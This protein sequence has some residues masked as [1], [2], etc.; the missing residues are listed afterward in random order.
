MDIQAATRIKAGMTMAHILSTKSNKDAMTSLIASQI[1]HHSWG[2]RV[3]CAW[4][5]KAMAT[6]GPDGAKFASEQEEADTKMIYHLSLLDKDVEATVVSP[7]TDVLVLLLRHFPKIPPNTCLQLGKTTFNVQLLHDKL[8]SHADVITSFHALTGCDTTCA[9]FRKG[10]L[11]AWPVFQAADQAT[12]DALGT[13]RSPGPLTQES[14]DVL[15]RFVSGIYGYTCSLPQARWT[16]LQKK[17]VGAA[18]A[19]PTVAATTQHIMRAQ[20]QAVVW[21]G[22]VKKELVTLDP[23][24]YGYGADLAPIPSTLPPA[25][26]GIMDGMQCGCK[27]NCSTNRCR[28][29]RLQT[30][31]SELCNCSP[32]MCIN[33]EEDGHEDVDGVDD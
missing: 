7:D 5:D 21:E 20:L 10:K 15:C 9:L 33:D 32:E 23:T 18:L 6:S 25:P 1:Q 26:Q 8:G 12:L 3:V 16:A 19:P 17:K 13:L 22:A 14:L 27:T 11:Q 30:P 24:K 29:Q 2:L 4:R 31:C 28:C